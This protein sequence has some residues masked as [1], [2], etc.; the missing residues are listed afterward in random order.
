MND[1]KSLGDYHIVIVN[2]DIQRE[3]KGFKEFQKEVE[4]MLIVSNI[5]SFNKA[6]LSVDQDRTVLK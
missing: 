3:L 6:I 1:A 4:K 5:K 2:S